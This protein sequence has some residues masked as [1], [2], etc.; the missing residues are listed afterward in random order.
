MKAK[1]LES[2]SGLPA[3]RKQIE[4][5]TRERDEIARERDEVAAEHDEVAAHVRGE[6]EQAFITRLTEERDEL[7]AE[8]RRLRERTR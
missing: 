3:L 2:K 5:L 1:N 8:V 4:D 7:L 6:N